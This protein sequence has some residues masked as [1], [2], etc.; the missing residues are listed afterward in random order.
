[1]IK[2][3]TKKHLAYILQVSENELDSI[4]SNIDTFYSEIIKSKVSKTG[5]IKYRILNPSLRRL[6][7]IQSRIHKRIL[8]KIP[9]PDYAYGAVKKRDNVMNARQ[10]QG[11]KF[12]FTT[13]LRKFF[14]SINHHQVFATFNS[15]GFSPTV[16][17]IL[18]QL[19]TYKGRLPQGAP[20]SST[21]SN[22][23]FLKTGTKLQTLATQHNLT[24]TTF[25]DDV[26]FSA[27]IDFK[28][29]V[30]QIIKIITDDGFKISHP[31]TFYRTRNPE[32]TGVI[33]KNNGLGL[34]RATKEKLES[35][36]NMTEEQAKG[37]LNYARRILT[38]T[39]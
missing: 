6:K 15:F 25:I 16:A 4:I 38:Y 32:V 1:M 24:F 19:T 18:T 21:L 8:I 5:K 10:H 13:D 35:L 26:T 2:I 37:I 36:E 39:K 30:K 29:L 9:L 3:Q 7:E 22:L 17:H 11:K 12:N 33:P 28:E 27:P 23:V 20:T 14:P 34:T 31:K